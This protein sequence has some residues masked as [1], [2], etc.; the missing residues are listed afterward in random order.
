MKKTI[1]LSVVS[2]TLLNAMDNKPMFPPMVPSLPIHKAVPHAKK[3]KAIVADS[4]NMI[5]PM[6]LHL[7]PP[8]EI[9]LIKC[10][11]E[12]NMPSKALVEKRLS[13]LLKKKVKVLKIEIVKKFNQLYKVT[14]NGGVI[15]TNKNADAFIRQ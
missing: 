11:N 10:K 8:M 15:L 4:C 3:A 7:P 9:A 13:T 5:P 2:L 6:I 1:L 12:S 14:Y